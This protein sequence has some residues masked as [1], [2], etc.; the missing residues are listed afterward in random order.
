MDNVYR[1]AQEEIHS[2]KKM[3]NTT[4]LLM[5]ANEF[6]QAEIKR[7]DIFST[8]P[9]FKHKENDVSNTNANFT[10]VVKK[11]QTQIYKAEKTINSKLRI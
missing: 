6:I 10:I 1:A 4:N 11:Y 2:M 8:H 5:K 7:K 9:F 3:V